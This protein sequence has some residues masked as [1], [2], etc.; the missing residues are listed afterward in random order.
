[1]KIL[2]TWIP[3]LL[4]GVVLCTATA[5]AVAGAENPESR[6]KHVAEQGAGVMPFDL[7]RTTHFFDANAA[8]GVQAVTAND[9]NDRAQ[10]ALIRSHLAL[11]AKQFA[12]GDFSDPAT[13][14]GNGMPGLAT[15]AASSGKLKITYKERPD[16]ASI[17]YVSND[18]DVIAAIHDWFAAQR[19]DHAAHEHMHH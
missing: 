14:H 19:S 13:I 9:K 3:C 17:T 15:L 6:Q 5:V 18:G 2:C 10:I 4:S 12:K 1:M 11:E 16:G 8:G 7:K